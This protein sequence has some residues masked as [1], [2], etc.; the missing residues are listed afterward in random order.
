[1][2]RS[3][4]ITAQVALNSPSCVCSGSYNSEPLPPT[5]VCVSAISGCWLSSSSEIYIVSITVRTGQNVLFHLTLH[6]LTAEYRTD[7]KQSSLHA[8]REVI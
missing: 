5:V 8:S 4:V 2:Y 6:D 3:L 1:M 7:A